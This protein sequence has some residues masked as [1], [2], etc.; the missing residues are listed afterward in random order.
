MEFFLDTGVIAEI[1]EAVLLCDRK[2]LLY[3]FFYYSKSMSVFVTFS[4]IDSQV[5]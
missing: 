4:I 2:P 1:K 3:Y 5:V